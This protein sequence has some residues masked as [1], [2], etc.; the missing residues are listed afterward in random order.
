MANTPSLENKTL[1]SAWDGLSPHLIASIY[2]IE[3]TESGAYARTKNTDPDIVQTPFS[4]ASMEISLNWQSAFE[5]SGPE[6]RAPT[7]L[8]M[9]QSGALQPIIDAVAGFAGDG[10]SEGLLRGIATNAQQ[11]SN[12]FIRQ[13]E[14]RTG[15]TKLNSTQVFNGM[16]P[17]KFQ[18]TA[19]F[20]AW[21]DPYAEVEAPF[22]KLMSWSLPVKLS[23][24][25]SILARSV[26]SARG[27]TGFIDAL[28]PSIAPV[29]VALRYKKRTYAPL[30]IESVTDPI[31]SPID[32]EGRFI[33]KAVPMTL[34]T[35]TAID[36]DDW[37]NYRKVEI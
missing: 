36:R 33:E 14:G 29:L 32:V 31:S 7:L 30:V 16:P 10:S 28:V 3:R 4:E 26:N 27:E 17:V 35:L 6:N 19:L 2:Q 20:R 18:V 1:S 13:F 21:R 9:L 11:E 15:I 23:P 37:T 8:A 5:H 22:E 34:A 24:D 12:R 25:G